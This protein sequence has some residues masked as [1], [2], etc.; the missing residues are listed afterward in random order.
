[1]LKSLWCCCTTS[2]PGQD[3]SISQQQS[4]LIWASQ[5]DES[6]S[7]WNLKQW[8]EEAH[9]FKDENGGRVIQACER[10]PDEVPD[11]EMQQE[12]LYFPLPMLCC[13]AVNSGPEGYD[14]TSF[15]A[16]LKKAPGHQL[17]LLLDDLDH[18]H[19]VVYQVKPGGLIDAWNQTAPKDA[20][21]SAGDLLLQVNGS[22][23]G[24][25]DL[26]ARLRE[27]S[28]ATEP[29]GTISLRFQHPRISYVSLVKQGRP[30][31]I[32]VAPVDERQPG[33]GIIIEEVSADGALSD[34]NATQGHK[35]QP[36]SRIV[37]VNGG[38]RHKSMLTT[39]QSNDYL[40]I[41]VIDW[42]DRRDNP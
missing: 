38:R 21:V 20:V 33:T 31:G 34:W 30:L 7:S 24:A 17:G 32:T 6:T 14:P 36:G 19:C 37:A 22:P 40:N 8:D 13:S 41:K 1:M 2:R 29:E 10:P 16:S 15:V 23:G 3:V 5:N 42:P 39:L 4:Q 11:R 28:Q 35:V 9:M 27:S 18:S 12:P 26:T 25:Q